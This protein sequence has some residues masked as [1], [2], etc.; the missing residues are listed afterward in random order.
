MGT[1]VQILGQTYVVKGNE[2]PD[3]IRELASFLDG[4]IKDVYSA[5][6][7]TPPLKAT[8]LAALNI[9]DELFRTRS[10]QSALSR[11]MREIE[12]KADA[13]LGLFEQDQT[14]KMW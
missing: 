1:E 14:N 8:I 6:P 4:R 2:P 11:G 5:L 7:G 9:T 10:E 13:M 3:Y 12:T